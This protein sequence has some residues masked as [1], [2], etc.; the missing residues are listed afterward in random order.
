[1]IRRFRNEIAPKVEFIQHHQ[2][3]LDSGKYRVDLVQRIKPVRPVEIPEDKWTPKVPTQDLGT[4]SSLT[5][6]VAGERFSA[7]S[8]QQI[9]G[10]FPAEGSLGDHSNV[11]PHITLTRSTLPWE[12]SPDNDNH[13][14]PWLAL[15]LFHDQDFDSKED[16]PEPRV[17]KLSELG[18]ALEPGQDPNDPVTVIEVKRRLLEPVLP[19]KSELGFLAHVRQLKDTNNNPLP[20]ESTLATVLCN[21]LPQAGGTSTAYLV[22]VEGRYL[23]GGEGF[24]FQN[25]PNDDDLIRLVCLKSWRF[26]CFDPKQSFTALLTNVDHEPGTLRLPGSGNAEADRYLAMG[27]LP[28]PHALRQG[29]R[30]VSWYHGPL[31]PGDVPAPEQVTALSADELLRYEARTGMF[32]VSYAAAWELGRML[33][34]QNQ[35]V[36]LALYQWKRAG[37]IAQR[38][39]EQR[40]AGRTLSRLPFRSARTQ[41]PMP[42]SVE[43]WFDDLRVLRGVPF[44]Y[45]VPDERLLP[46]E[47]LRFFHLDRRW[48]KCLLDGASSIGRATEGERRREMR[49]G[50]TPASEPDL[51]VTGFLLRSAVVSGWPELIV[52]GYNVV[53]PGNDFHPSDA[54]VLDLLRME[55]LSDNVLLCLFEGDVK[56]VDIHLK[57]EKM[58]FGVDA[59]TGTPPTFHKTLRDPAT[60]EE[61]EGSTIAIPW[62]RDQEHGVIDV[63][64]LAPKVQVSMRRSTMTSAPFALQMIEG[65]QKVR[66]TQKASS[67]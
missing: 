24:D 33:T 22:S 23:Q 65:V 56:T 29:D 7:L 18:A 42:A 66:F 20:G 43:A 64:E 49:S 59:P 28:L 34:L 41:A 60:G 31:S 5:F 30:T 11:L 8:P 19:R 37:G 4:P 12:R 3:P 58:H 47:S 40:R 15:L 38:S 9:A 16:R 48:M 13:E 17:M 50:F 25:A 14:L 51:L 57:P 45:L 36:A 62:T 55:R 67:P 54:G 26:T 39:L 10:L 52:D 46:V 35:A 63:A 61:I 2:P 1:M 32:D 53:V 6:V 21:R 27:Y 44:D